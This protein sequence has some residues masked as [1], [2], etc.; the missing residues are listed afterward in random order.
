LLYK[1]VLQNTVFGP[2]LDVVYGTLAFWT[3]VGSCITCVTAELKSTPQHCCHTSLL[4]SFSFPSLFCVKIYMFWEL[5]KVDLNT[6]D[7]GQRGFYCLLCLL[8]WSACVL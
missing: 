3:M 2:A 4:Q 7:E 6:S 5:G 8:Y 1:K